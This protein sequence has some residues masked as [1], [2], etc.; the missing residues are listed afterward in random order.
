MQSPG[1]EK[2][3]TGSK[4][5]GAVG[6]AT[7]KG[8]W[9]AKVKEGERRPTNKMQF[10]DFGGESFKEMIVIW[11]GLRPEIQGSQTWARVLPQARLASWS[12]CL[13]IFGLHVITWKWPLR[14]IPALRTLEI[15]RAKDFGDQERQEREKSVITVVISKRKCH[16]QEQKLAG[17]D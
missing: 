2:L 6:E 17:K 13:N 10:H 15:L 9:E 1:E 11:E 5:W 14:S 4:A 16:H 12:K 3:R 7:H 8:D